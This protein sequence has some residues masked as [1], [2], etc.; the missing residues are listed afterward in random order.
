MTYSPDQDY[1]VQIAIRE[2]QSTYGDTVSVLEKSK[3]LLKFGRNENVTATAT[4][5]T[6]WQAG[7]NETYIEDNLIVQ[8]SSTNVGDTTAAIV[9]GHTISASGSAAAYTFVTQTISLS[10]QNAVALTTPLAR[11]SRV[12]NLGST[13]WAGAIYVA[14]SATLSLGSP[15]QAAKIHMRLAPGEQQSFKAATTFSE[16]D[17]FILTRAT[18]S[19]KKKTSSSVDFR[20]EIKRPGQVFRPFFEISLNSTG[21]NT[22]TKA[23]LPYVIVPKNSDIR[24]R[25]SADAT[26]ASVDASF[27]GYLALI[28]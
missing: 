3:T 11:C 21:Q 18:F 2:I 26:G 9:E 10:G 15:S 23:F 1:A 19:V 20:L 4:Y 25:C 6:V 27:H 13:S 14:Q 22:F 17:Y 7:G 24:V 8:I 5:E 16:S 28:V 12:A